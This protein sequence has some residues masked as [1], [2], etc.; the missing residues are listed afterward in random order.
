MTRT[1]HCLALAMAFAASAAGLRAAD[2]EVA[3][4]VEQLRHSDA[5][6]RE[7]AASTLAGMKKR[8][9]QP[10]VRALGDDPITRIAAAQALEKMGPDA[11]PALPYLILA[12]GHRD[13]A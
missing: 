4:W 1:I 8:A 2:A 5:G 10:L 12:L 11:V 9:L 6:T 3:R 7:R 13:Y